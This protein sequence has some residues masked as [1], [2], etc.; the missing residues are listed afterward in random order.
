[1]PRDDDDEILMKAVEVQRQI[2]ERQKR[3]RGDE[4]VMPDEGQFNR[5]MSKSRTFA[6]SFTG[7][8]LVFGAVAY[9]PW[10]LMQQFNRRLLQ[11]YCTGRVLDMHPALED[12]QSL[13]ALY[14]SCRVH[15]VA[16][17]LRRLEEVPEGEKRFVPKRGTRDIGD[18]ENV[19]EQEAVR[20]GARFAVANDSVLVE[21]Q[22]SFTTM[23]D[24]DSKVSAANLG[25]FD[26]VVSKSWLT[27]LCEDRAKEMLLKMHAYVGESEDAAAAR[28]GESGSADQGPAVGHIVLIDFGKSSIG[29]LNRALEFFKHESGS[30]MFLGH[31]YEQWFRDDP[32][33]SSK[34]HV[35][36]HTRRFFGVH[37]AFVLTAK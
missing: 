23:D 9:A 26:T 24:G 35:L 5:L 13:V 20:N 7:A 11:K 4:P 21:S 27:E 34:F 30:G 33:I 19:S 17:F 2:S 10:F 22:I 29:V 28:K 36:S 31:N 6:T 12:T 14:E 25:K 37:H 18:E 16:F 32:I 1:M 15:Q 3:D 8:L